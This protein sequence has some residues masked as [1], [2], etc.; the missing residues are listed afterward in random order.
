MNK[1]LWTYGGLSIVGVVAWAAVGQRPVGGV[2][3]TVTR[4]TAIPSAPSP[5]A[6]THATLERPMLAPA[7]R[8]AFAAVAPP[9][10]P[11]APPPPP[12]AKKS[13]EPPPP[14]APP[15][16]NLRFAGRMLAPDGSQVVFATLGNETVT[17]AAGTSLANGYRVE[18]IGD[19]A[20]EFMYPPL[21]ARARLDIPSA[22]AFEIR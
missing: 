18:K 7:M 1:R 11:A 4:D 21:S 5:V 19:T 15:A 14:P 10:P 6:A 16:L 2:T 20:V 9:P 13:E 3:P 17:L 12:S 8:D 22:P